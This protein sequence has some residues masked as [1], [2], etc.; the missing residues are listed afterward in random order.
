MLF[1]L[2]VE[3]RLGDGGIVDFAVTVAPIADKI[4]DDIG[5]KL[6]AVLGRHPGYADDGVYIFSVDVEDGNGLAARDASCE[7]CRMFLV[8]VRSESEKIVGNYVDGPADG[9]PAEVR[10]IHGFGEDALSGKG[11]IAVDEQWDIF[12]APTF[13]GAVLLGARAAYR[14]GIDGFEVTGI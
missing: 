6:V 11:R 7:A 4:D 1:D 10:V 12:F 9:V 5:A 14:N 13:S 3:N 8:V 2:L